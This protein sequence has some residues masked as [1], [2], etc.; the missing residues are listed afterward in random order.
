ML[1]T[2]DACKLE[3]VKKAMHDAGLDAD[4][5][6]AFDEVNL[7]KLH[8]EGYMTAIAFKS[9]REQDLRDCNIPR[10]LIGVLFQGKCLYFYHRR[11]KW[12]QWCSRCGLVSL[13]VYPCRCA[14]DTTGYCCPSFIWEG[15]FR[16]VFL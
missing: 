1:S 11:W 7:L 15:D 12:Q 4:R 16:H 9:A 2:A 10:G 6:S 13:S 3:L 5:V 8:A 14:D